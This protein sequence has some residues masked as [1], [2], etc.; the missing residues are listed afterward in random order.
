MKL[1][2]YVTLRHSAII[3]L[4]YVIMHGTMSHAVLRHRLAT[5]LDVRGLRWLQ[6]RD[7]HAALECF[8]EASQLDPLC[9]RFLV[10]RAIAHTKLGE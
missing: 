7:A 9:P 6:F 5:M 2:H 4:R 8:E 10:H 1:A 3:D